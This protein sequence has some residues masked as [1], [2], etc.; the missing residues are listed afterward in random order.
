VIRLF[1]RERET[2]FDGTNVSGNT[3]HNGKHFCINF[4]NRIRAGQIYTIHIINCGNFFPP[5]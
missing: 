5:V 3:G 2:N 1:V 4:V